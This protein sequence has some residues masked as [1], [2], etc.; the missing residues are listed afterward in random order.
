MRE[1]SQLT[2]EAAL[3][4]EGSWGDTLSSRG[5]EG[6]PGRSGCHGRRVEVNDALARC[7]NS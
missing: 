7:R 5:A 1:K 4:G 2:G 6:E 3:S